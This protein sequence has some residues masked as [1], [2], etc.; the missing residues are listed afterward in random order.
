[1]FEP[2]HNRA[3][4]CYARAVG[5]PQKLLLANKLCAKAKCC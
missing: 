1:M 4:G 5:S 3:L 2:A